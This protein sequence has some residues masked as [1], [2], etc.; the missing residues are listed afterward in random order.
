MMSKNQA[1]TLIV[2]W[3]G[4]RRAEA[5]EELIE[6]SRM[7]MESNPNWQVHYAFV[8]F[9]QPSLEDK[10]R[11]LVAL[12]EKTIVLAPVFLTVG[13]HLA[14]GLPQR[15]EVLEEENPGLQLIMAHHLGA[16]PLIAQLITK[17]ALGAFAT[18]EVN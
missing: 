14:Q 16:D 8:E 2:V 6:L 7:V 1:K 12:G 10:V 13:N 18:L 3:H 5:N 15:F 17:R 11:E 4:S 9:A